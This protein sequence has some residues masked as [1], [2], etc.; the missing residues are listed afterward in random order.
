VYKFIKYPSHPWNSSTKYSSFLKY[1]PLKFSLDNSILIER[2]YVN[3]GSILQLTALSPEALGRH[4]IPKGIL[5]E[6]L[7]NSNKT[8]LKQYI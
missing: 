3:N 8:V 6:Y 1:P 2:K 4:V 7:K 5:T